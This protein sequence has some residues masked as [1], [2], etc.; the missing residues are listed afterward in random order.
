M[1]LPSVELELSGA[2]RGYAL[3][4]SCSKGDDKYRFRFGDI[5]TD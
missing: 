1:N 4:W 5:Q 2:Y 3:K